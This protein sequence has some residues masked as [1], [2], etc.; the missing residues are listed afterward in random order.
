MNGDVW[1]CPGP[2]T[3]AMRTV[4]RHRYVWQKNG[5]RGLPDGFIGGKI[6]AL[7]WDFPN[8]SPQD[9]VNNTHARVGGDGEEEGAE[10][11]FRCSHAD[12]IS[13]LILADELG[14]YSKICERP[15]SVCNSH[16]AVHAFLEKSGSICYVVEIDEH[17]TY[18]LTLPPGKARYVSRYT[19]AMMNR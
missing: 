9:L 12:N 13:I 3:P 4:G 10:H 18:K 2:S 15:L 11:K 7:Y 17:D 16:H 8:G 5:V 6:K 1:S 14:N 19:S